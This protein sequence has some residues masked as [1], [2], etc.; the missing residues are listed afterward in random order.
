[1]PAS[2]VCI[3]HATG[4]LGEEVGRLVA[5]R[6]GLRYLDE[7]I[8]LDAA[9]REAVEPEQLAA[10]ER[11]RAGL[12]RLH[13]DVFTGGA[14]D[15][16]LRSMIRES[17][18]AAAAGGEAVIVAH[19]AAMALAGDP[20]AIR[21]LVTGSP[22]VRAARI[23]AAARLDPPEAAKRVDAADKGR[24][25]YF[26]SFYGLDRELPVHYDL[27]VNTDRITAELAATLVSEAAG[28]VGG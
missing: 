21:V 28:T 1:M 9:E 10:V 7:E 20:R 12:G 17:I 23:A 13:I 25:A 26:K 2:I 5:E 6:L 22:G 8:L 4:A 24:A 18:G 11:R 14:V 27:V 3:S 19:A 15:A 16:I